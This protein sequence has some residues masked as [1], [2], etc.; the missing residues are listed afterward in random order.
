MGNTSAR[1][2]DLAL[3]FSGRI[4]KKSDFKYPIISYPN[5]CILCFRFR[6]S[7]LLQYSKIPS[8]INCDAPS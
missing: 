3:H 7:Y 1:E 6:I 4:L 8:V 5:P 2:K